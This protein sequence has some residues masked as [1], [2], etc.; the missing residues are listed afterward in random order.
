MTGSRAWCSTWPATTASTGSRSASSPARRSTCASTTAPWTSLCAVEVR[1][2]VSVFL[3]ERLE[4]VKGAPAARRAHLD[5][6]VAALWPSRAETRSAYSR[7]LAQRNA[8]VARIRAGAAGPAALDA[9]DA[10]ARAAR[11]SADGRSGG[12]GGGAAAVVR[13][14]GRTARASRGGGA[15]LPAALRCLGRGRAG[16]RAARAAHGRPRARVH[17]ARAA[18]RRAPAAAGRRRRFARTARRDSSAPPCWRC[19]SP[20]APCLP[21]AAPARR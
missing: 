20:S 19:C 21:S 3:P 17:R 4:L 8:L 6:F 12:G 18:P 11:C 5:Q 16:R 2:L 13:R 14:P 9:W 10:R 7:A 15:A 1:P